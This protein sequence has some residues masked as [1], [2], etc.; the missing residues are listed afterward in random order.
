M[1]N[2]NRNLL[3]ANLQAFFHRYPQSRARFASAIP[4]EVVDPENLPVLALESH[5]RPPRIVVLEGFGLG[6]TFF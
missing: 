1:K 3:E 4:E 5:G 2:F 6:S